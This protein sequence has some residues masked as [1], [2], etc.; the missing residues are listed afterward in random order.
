MCDATTDEEAVG[1]RGSGVDARERAGRQY[2]A[3]L[4]G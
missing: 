1:G 2:L 3:R 4:D